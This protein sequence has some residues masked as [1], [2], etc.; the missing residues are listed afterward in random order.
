MPTS[1]DDDVAGAE[2]AMATLMSLLLSLTSPQLPCDADSRP[3]VSSAVFT[4]CNLRV[5][6]SRCHQ[7]R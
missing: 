6:V 3:S 4:R 2:R 5:H 1:R 7:E